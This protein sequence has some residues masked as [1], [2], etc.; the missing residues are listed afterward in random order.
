MNR[1]GRSASRPTSA[2]QAKSLYP[3]ALSAAVFDDVPAVGIRGDRLEFHRLGADYA[4]YK[5]YQRALVIVHGATN[6]Y[7]NR[8]FRPRNKDQKRN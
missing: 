5:G 6:S 7:R 2:H 3:A 4:G 1:A 8:S